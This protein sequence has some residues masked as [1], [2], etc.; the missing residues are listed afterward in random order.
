MRV[1][2]IS[3]FYLILVFSALG[4]K[5]DVTICR[6]STS[7]SKNVPYALNFLGKKKTDAFNLFGYCN[8]PNIS[9]NYIWLNFTPNSFGNLDFVFGNKPDSL[10]IFVFECKT[11]DP[12]N[13]IIEKRA[14]LV[15]CHFN[16]VKSA[17]YESKPIFLN[18]N[19]SYFIA[20]N[21]A[22]GST[23][24]LDFTLKFEESDQFGAYLEDSLSLNL[25]SRY[26]QPIYAL[27]LVNEINKK[28]VVARIYISSTGNLDGAYRASDLRLNNTKNLKANLRIDAQGYFSKDLLEH[29][30]IGN[31]SSH[32]TITLVPITSGAI[33]KL[34]DINFVGGLAV[35][36]DESL[37]KLKRLKDFLVLNPSISIEI[38]GHVNEEGANSMSSQRLSKKRAQKIMR[39]LVQNGIEPIRLKAIGYGNS[40]PLF[41]FPV[42]DNQRE[43]NRRVEIKVD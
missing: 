11:N 34:D 22:K 43:A 15:L 18:D 33:A 28:P 35:I 26:D 21:T 3:L 40:K 24:K 37:P 30:I 42:D 10:T 41:Q 16:S 31:Q 29:K 13:E 2:I 25:V 19:S 32:D 23:A 12:C 36:S 9:N 8:F 20:F 14:N 17:P 7:V 4:Q 1:T 6:G 39:Y 27:H 38:Q 5:S